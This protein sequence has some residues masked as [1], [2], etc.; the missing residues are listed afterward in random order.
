MCQ[1]V[2]VKI[3]QVASLFAAKATSLRYAHWRG[4][5]ALA[6]YINE[7]QN[8][9]NEAIERDEP[10]SHALKKR[11]IRARKPIDEG[12]GIVNPSRQFCSLSARAGW[13]EHV[14]PGYYGERAD[15]HY[16]ACLQVLLR[17]QVAAATKLWSL[18]PEFEAISRDV[19][20]LALTLKGEIPHIDSGHEE[21]GK[22]EKGER[23][24]MA[25]N[26][27]EDD[28][29]GFTSDSEG[30]ESENSDTGVASLLDRLSEDDDSDAENSLNETQPMVRLSGEGLVSRFPYYINVAVLLISCWI[31]RLPVTYSDILK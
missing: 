13:T 3:P 11:A 29:E 15:F 22:Q 19:W 7:A 25:A 12:P 5:L 16:L 20:S 27:D 21:Q 30:S 31:L 14:P 4:Q 1:G 18:P 23:T 9:R 10:P 6:S 28:S 2:G 8:Y 26:S 17:K 24:P